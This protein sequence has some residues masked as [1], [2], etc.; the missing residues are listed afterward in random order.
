MALIDLINL[1]NKTQKVGLS[2]ERVTAMIPEA[3]KLI[4]FW[5]DYPDLFVDFMAQGTTFKLYY[6]QRCFLR[7]VV[8]H[9]YF[10]GVFPRAYSKSFLSVMVLMIRCILY[11]GAKLFVTA[12]GKEQ[13]A[14]ILKDKVQEICN[15][16][17]TFEREIDW[18]RGKTVFSKDKVQ[19]V[20]K[21]KSV[22]DNIAAKESSRGQR[23]HGF[24]GEECVGIDGKIL[25]E[26]LIPITNISRR[27][28][29]G[30][31]IPEEKLNKSQCMITTAGYKN[32]FSYDKLIQFLIWQIVKPEQ[33]IC[34]GGTWRLPVKMG[35]FDKNF[36]SELKNDG[37]FNESSFEREYESIWSGTAEN[38]FFRSE[39]FDRSRKLLQPEYEYSKRSSHG[40]Y[41]VVSVDV[42]RRGCETIITILKVTPQPQG[43][44]IKSVVNI[45][46]LED[47]HF[48]DQAIYIKKLFYKYKAKQVVLD[49][50]GLGIGLIDYMVKSQ[51]DPD[52]GD[53]LP[54]FGV[55]N[56]PDGYYKQYR[57]PYTEY[58]ALYIIKA[59]AAINTEAHTN[60][61]SQLTSGKIKFLI[62]DNQAKTKLLGTTKGQN[63]SPEERAKYLKPFIQTSILKEEL[64]NL[65]E[66]NEGVNIILKQV[67]RS[68]GKDR[69]S[70]LEYGLYYI[71]EVEESKK[72]RKRFNV[73]DLLLMN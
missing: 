31:T 2:E 24:V 64:L 71:R 60:V 62:P 8:R 32:T 59:N 3:R 13:S 47:A 7:A 69:F 1:S 36:I 39:V 15:L 10:Y 61:Q 38:A 18:T 52:T 55:S 45:F 54:D 57:T 49:G 35:L 42:G 27:L 23:R 26:V 20:F 65:R 9:K 14:S 40:A 46:S 37:T 6:Y 12:G 28:P 53:T 34:L 73:K 68:I 51:I 43:A 63:M 70:S 29:D 58:D 50:N 19:V 16:I 25:S 66:E 11:P 22:F 72:K 33:S 21:N 4:G 5:R 56:D 67:N 41:Y 30:T 48:E 44:S 17:P